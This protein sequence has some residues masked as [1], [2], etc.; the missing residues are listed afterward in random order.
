MA[1]PTSFFHLHENQET[2]FSEKIVVVWPLKII[3]ADLA[4]QLPGGQGQGVRICLIDSGLDQTMPNLK[5]VVI[6]GRNFLDNENADDL[7]DSEHRH[8]TNIAQ[9]LVGR[10]RAGFSGVAPAAKLV[11]AKVFDHQGKATRKDVIE[12]LTYCADRADII[13]LSFNVDSEINQLGNSPSGLSLTMAMAKSKGLSLF[14]PA[15]QEEKGSNAS[16][17]DPSVYVVGAV[18]RQGRLPDFIRETQP[19]LSFLA[20]GIRIPILNKAGGY[21]FVT[22]NEYSA[23][24][25]TGVEAIRRS[26]GASALGF[27]DLGLPDRA[28]GEGL[29]DALETALN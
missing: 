26:R 19:Q 17:L 6:E 11:I 25:E 18:D 15:S 29:I 2:G 10:A 9:I 27:R 8:G 21:S 1:S 23:A 14:A 22:G 13:N 24:M 7:T 3:R 4:H 5:D 20:P 16:F 12:A 28:Q